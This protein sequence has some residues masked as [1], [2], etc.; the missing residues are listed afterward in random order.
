MRLRAVVLDDEP[1]IR[2][3]LWTLCDRRGYE[4][5]T[6]P[7]PGLCPLD[8]MD[9]CP[10]PP[11]TVCADLRLSDLHMPEVQGLDLVEDL[12]AKACVAPHLGLMSAAWS[13]AAHARAG[14]L[15]CRLFPKPFALAELLAWFDTVEAHVAPTRALLEWRGQGWRIEPPVPED[16]GEPAPRRREGPTGEERGA[17]PVGPFGPWF[18]RRVAAAVQAGELPGHLLERLRREL[19]GAEPPAQAGG[20]ALPV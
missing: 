12:L 18:L 7:D 2:Q 9:R 19:A 16:R 5:L 8:V 6:F 20:E 4:V 1:I 15:G 11:G 14:R 10:C 3:L 13:A 17:D